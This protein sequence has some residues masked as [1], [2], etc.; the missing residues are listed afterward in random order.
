MLS[1]C[2][3]PVQERTRTGTDSRA[4]AGVTPNARAAVTHIATSHRLEGTIPPLPRIS[5][6]NPDE[7]NHAT[8]IFVKTA[9]HEPSG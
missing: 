5:R 7:H 6:R 1:S 9:S 8:R 3:V 4:L 2:Q